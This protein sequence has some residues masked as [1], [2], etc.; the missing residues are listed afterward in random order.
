MGPEHLVKVTQYLVRIEDLPLY[1][2]IRV[3]WLKD[4]RP[5]SMLVIVPGLVRPYILIEVEGYAVAPLEI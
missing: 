2:P 4:N 3:K 1:P 5:A